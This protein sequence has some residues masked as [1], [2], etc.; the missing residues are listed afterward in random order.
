MQ[1]AKQSSPNSIHVSVQRSSSHDELLWWI[2][3]NHRGS[4][5]AIE[6]FSVV[7]HIFALQNRN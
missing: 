3:R 7:S 1:L 5:M 4:T 6:G 2:K